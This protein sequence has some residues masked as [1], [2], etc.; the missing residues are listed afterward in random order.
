MSS[1]VIE[2]ASE[3]E[4]ENSSSSD[5]E[6]FPDSPVKQKCKR[7]CIHLLFERYERNIDTVETGRNN[8]A[9]DNEKNFEVAKEKQ[10][11]H[12]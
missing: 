11:I 6:T 9:D 1:S 4:N 12:P 8:E 2:S 10:D 5:N 7:R 3:N